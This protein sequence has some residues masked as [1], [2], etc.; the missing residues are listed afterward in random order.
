[1]KLTSHIIKKIASLHGSGL[2]Q[3]AI[4]KQLGMS[5]SS[6]SIA[7]NRHKGTFGKEP[8]RPVSA[9]LTDLEMDFLIE[10]AALAGVSKSD[11]IRK[12]I[13]KSAGMF[14]PDVETNSKLTG[15][16]SELSRIGNNLNQMAT[17]LNRA[18]AND[19][20]PKL[21]KVD[22]DKIEDLWVHVAVLTKGIK[23]MLNRNSKNIRA[24]KDG[25]L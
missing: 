20:V 10:Q 14:E 19:S 6:I 5:Q 23:A 15:L 2:T 8:T 3:S 22:R 1:M 24:F 21:Y 11:Y 17:V 7:I 18:L 16:I 9:R 13:R 25:D 4:A 12:I